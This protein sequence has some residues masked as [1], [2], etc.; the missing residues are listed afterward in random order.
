M[1][2]ELLQ[3]VLTIRIIPRNTIPIGQVSGL[4]PI[5]AISLPDRHATSVGSA[6]MTDAEIFLSAI[7]GE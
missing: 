6:R 4:W 7:F 5:H 2:G 3:P 1:D